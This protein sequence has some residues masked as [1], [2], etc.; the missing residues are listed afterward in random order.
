[1]SKMFGSIPGGGGDNP[2]MKSLQEMS[3]KAEKILARYGVSEDALA[4]ASPTSAPDEQGIAVLAAGIRDKSGFV[5]EMMQVMNSM[6]TK[7]SP[8]HMNWESATLS[9]L[10]IDG[11]SAS[12]TIKIDGDENP[13]RF[14]RVG[15][16]WLVELMDQ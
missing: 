13:I 10:T 4:K 14:Q 9:N 15:G 2:E 3:Q 8:G 1:M 11:D 5:G 12:G 7:N 6:A 16:A